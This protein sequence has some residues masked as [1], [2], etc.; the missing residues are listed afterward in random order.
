MYNADIM[1]DDI[2]KVIIS[3]GE[4]A[5]RVSAMADEMVQTYGQPDEGITIVTVLAGSLV[6]L[7]DLIRRLPLRMRIALVTAS[8]YAGKATTA[9][10]IHLESTTLPDLRNRNVLIV[11]D[12]VETGGTL[13]LVQAAVRRLC[14]RRIRTAVLLRK[15]TK[16]PSDVPIDFVG[17]DIGDDFVVGYGLDYDGLYRNLPFIAVLKPEMYNAESAL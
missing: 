16:A 13:R 4:I 9:G 15:T 14:P 17:F 11:D 5:E 3:S 8:S 12:I 10:K 2:A 7:S 1:E 6:F